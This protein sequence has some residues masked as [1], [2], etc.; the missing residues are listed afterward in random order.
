MKSRIGRTQSIHK[1]QVQFLLYFIIFIL[2]IFNILFLCLI[3]CSDFVYFM[4]NLFIVV[5]RTNFEHLSE[6]VLILL[7]ES[8]KFWKQVD[9]VAWSQK[10][11]FLQLCEISQLCEFWQDC[12]NQWHSCN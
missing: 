6:G 9:P 5:F 7:Q 2:F 1:L 3:F 4:Y 8:K 10:H 12:E 11:K